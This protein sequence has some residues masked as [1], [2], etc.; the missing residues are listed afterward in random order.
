[1]ST[2]RGTPR[3]GLLLPALILGAALAVR[4]A[5]IAATPDLR[6]RSDP[7][8]YHRLA[9]SLDAGHGFGTTVVAPGGGPTAFR[10][11]M[12]PVVLAAVYK[13]TGVH[14]T[15]AR[16]FQALLGT[17]SVALIG[18]LAWSVWG[19]RT[20]LVAMAVAAVYPPLV[21]A[22]G[23]LLSESL[24]IPLEL[25]AVLCAMRARTSRRAPAWAVAAGL[26]TGLGILTRPNSAVLVVPVVLLSLTGVRPVR[27]LA[28]PALIVVV[29]ALVLVP[30][31]VRD[32]N[33][34]GHVVPLTTQTGLVAAGTYNDTSAHDRRAPAAW[35]PENLVPEYRHL[36]YGDEYG[37]ER[38]LRHAATRYVD[39]HPT[40]VARVMYWNTRRLFDTTGR[41][42]SRASWAAN[43]F[44]AGW[45][46]AAHYG[47]WVVAV[48][49]V[50]GAVTTNA[51]KAPG[52]LWLAPVLLWLVTVPVLGESRLR[53]TIEPF[54]V[55]LAALAIE[56][57][58]R[59][60][61]RRRAPVDDPVT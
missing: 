6:L 38:R 60:L 24:A 3:S 10:P 12:F 42:S 7:A 47:Y 29:A 30:W 46:D 33:V 39:A 32:R 22:G 52:A 40:Y 61:G 18:L 45:A 31:L 27:R 9:V 16:V 2:N 13:V 35:R 51:R 37:E 41:A 57:V 21:V 26:L 20:A 11:P 14:I 54:F 55:L 25:G 56:A 1:M 58:R 53:G 5:F 28:A 49:A 23:T 4:L 44:S 15:A 8:D 50:G 19:R 59:R 43:G 34:M 36:L 17:V 48:L